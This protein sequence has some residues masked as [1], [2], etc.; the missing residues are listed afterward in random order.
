MA[1][2]GSLDVLRNGFTDHGVKFRM[3]FFKPESGLNP[4]T[5]ELYQLNRLQVRY[6]KKN[7]N[8][9]DLLLSLNGV[10]V[11]TM[12]LKNQLTG[13]NAACAKQQY[14]STRDS[15]ELLFSFKKRTLVHF[16]VDADEVWMTTRLNGLQTV[17]LP[18][19]VSMK[20]GECQ[21]PKARKTARPFRRC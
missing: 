3:A 21:A 9:V 14:I 8:S 5:A 1:L 20:K 11:V 2:R 17:W 10:P 7:N 12:E 13:Q 18:F 15:R 16:A 19:P 6:S 4:E